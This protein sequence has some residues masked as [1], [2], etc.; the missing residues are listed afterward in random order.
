MT[1]HASVVRIPRQWF[2]ACLSTELR[3]AAPIARTLQDEPLVVFRDGEGRAAALADPWPHRN[4]PLSEGRVQD[5][6]LECRY[7]GWRFDREGECRAVPGLV[8]APGGKGRAAVHHA[9]RERDGLVWVWS[10]AGEG[11][12]SEP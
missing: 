3:G 2:V 9:V 11:P 12:A 4:A 7:H 5:G 10:T 6:L 1:G 8:G